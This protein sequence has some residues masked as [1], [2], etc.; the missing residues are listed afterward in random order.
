MSFLSAIRVALGALMLNKG[1]SILT[2]LGIVIG[3]SAVIAMVSAGNGARY[4][5]DDR[6][7]SVGKNLILLKPGSRVQQG[8]TTDPTPLTSEDASAIRR[9]VGPLLTG[10]AESRMAQRLVSTPSHTHGTV[11]VGSVPDLERV[12]NWKMS[13]G[14]FYNEEDLK[15]FAPVCLLGQVARQKLFPD[16]P[17]PIGKEIRVANL[18]RL[19]VIGV[20]GEK[21]RA[22]TGADQDDQVFVPI[23]TMEHLI[24]REAPIQVI[25]ATAKSEELVD[26]AKEE[27]IRVMHEQH[28]L[29][30][31]ASD[32]FDVSTVQEM[33]ELAVVLTRT[34]QLL[35][36]VIASISLLVGGI[37]IMNIMLVSVTE[38]TREIGIRMA[39]GATPW[40]VLRQFLIEAVVLALVG[41]IIGITLGL[42]GAIALA[43]FIDWPLVVDP[44]AVALAFG[45]SAA[46]G[47]FFGFY[48]ARKASRLDPIE[49]LRFE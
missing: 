11:I 46:V 23:T 26:R 24:A 44:K 15:G 28:H 40:D 32:D 14:R 22:P 47:I 30:A 48:P 25:V 2:S 18:A 34:M 29:K 37:G 49:A 17:D 33:A 5:L 1:R 39:I 45:V 20:L 27:I 21:G 41:G 12:R 7:S 43:H 3:I 9:Q 31:G 42:V 8:F 10:V 16:T 4:K 19:R 6:L 35:T 13:L 38:R 36:A